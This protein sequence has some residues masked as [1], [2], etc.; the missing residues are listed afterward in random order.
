[1]ADTAVGHHDRLPH[2]SCAEAVGVPVQ[3]GP[4]VRH[5]EIRGDDGTGG[6]SDRL[7]LGFVQREI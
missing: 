5:R 4:G 6:G 2:K 7:Y 1:V 3:R